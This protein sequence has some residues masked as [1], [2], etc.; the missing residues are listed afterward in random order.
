VAH[1]T[2]GA[3]TPGHPVVDQAEEVEDSAEIERTA[4]LYATRVVTGRDDVP[5]VDAGDYRALATKSG[6]IERATGVDA[7]AI[8]FAWARRNN[9]YA[10]AS[11]AAKALYRASGARRLLREHFDRNVDPESASESDR[12]LLHCV[13]GDPECDA[14]AH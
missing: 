2:S 4:E 8:I 5:A 7:G 6:Q 9:G 11:M 14:A 3:C 10:T 13:S 1:I 12:I